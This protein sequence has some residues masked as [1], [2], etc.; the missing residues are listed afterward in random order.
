MAECDKRVVGGLGWFGDMVASGGGG[1]AFV[2]RG[3]Q[4]GGGGWGGEARVG[5]W[6]CSGGGGDGSRGGGW[7]NAM[8]KATDCY[9]IRHR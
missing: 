2:G 7:A 9:E 6:G 3:G 8:Q 5:E 1:W 4:G